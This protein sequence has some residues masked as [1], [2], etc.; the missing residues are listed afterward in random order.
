MIDIILDS[1]GHEIAIIIP[2]SHSQDGVEFFSKNEYSQQIGYMRHREGYQIHAHTH[3]PV[4]RTV[5]HTQ[6]ALFIRYG[7]VQVDLFDEEGNGVQS[8]KLEAGDVILLVSGGHGF[9]M[10]SDSEMIEIKQGPYT[11]NDKKYL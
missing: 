2:F 11:G 10:L 7:K 5:K 6:E 8:R 4:A 9:T 3:L 1:K